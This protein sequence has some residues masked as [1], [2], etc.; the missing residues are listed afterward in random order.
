MKA[1]LSA[2]KETSVLTVDSLSL[3]VMLYEEG[4]RYLKEALEAY[5]KKEYEKKAERLIY[6]MEV[7]SELL[8]SLDLER[9]GE[10]AKNLRDIYTFMLRELL[11]FDAE[12]KPE[13]IKSV[14]EMLQ[15]LKEAFEEVKERG[16]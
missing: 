11:L 6:G 4:I 3:V 12:E 5:E 16:S 9:G 15:Q 8:A 10:I 2:Y 14:I 13:R 7:I 1:A